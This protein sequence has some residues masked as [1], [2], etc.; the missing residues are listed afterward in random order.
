MN[1]FALAYRTVITRPLANA[2]VAIYLFLPY[3]DLGL[4]I[5][6]MTIV[7]RIV[8]HPAISQT[9]RSQRAMAAIQPQLREIQERLKNDREAQARET[10][11][12]YRDAG[13]HPLSGCLPLLIQLPLL[14]GLYR[15]FW[16]G[17]A[18]SDPALLYPFLPTFT[19]FNP[20][21]FGLFNLTRPSVALAIAAGA[22]QF[23]Q[24]FFVPQPAAPQSPGGT[25]DFGRIMQ[26]QIRYFFPLMI[27][28]I[29]W[30]LP[31]ALAFY[32]T[33]F[34]LLAILQQKIIERT[35]Y[36]RDPRTHQP[37][38]GEDGHPGRR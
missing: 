18:F 13:V 38:A 6:A 29:S 9:V 32:W 3:H 20:I 24:S 23:L 1:V 12:R 28:A 11:A 27:A 2:L 15:L 10:M 33:A 31:S 5:L 7:V 36:E 17:L 19:G 22:S 35:T 25:G 4:A 16:R 26:W 8:L 30:S 21:A 34:N 37:D 14:I